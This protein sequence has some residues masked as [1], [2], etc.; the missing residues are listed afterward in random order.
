MFD[1]SVFTDITRIIMMLL[2]FITNRK[3]DR[4]HWMSYKCEQSRQK[5]TKTSP[6]S[7]CR[8]VLRSSTHDSTE[9]IERCPFLTFSVE[10]GPLST[11]FDFTGHCS[12]L[13]D[14]VRLCSVL[15]DFV[16]LYRT[17]FDF[18]RFYS[19]LFDRLC[20]NLSVI[21]RIYWELALVMRRQGLLSN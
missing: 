20:S 10:R 18:V 4:N 21:F 15:L 12:T 5:P 8:P 3:I 7:I 19:T 11:F 14:I 2:F 16:R 13:P 1:S 17:L 9:T 6:I